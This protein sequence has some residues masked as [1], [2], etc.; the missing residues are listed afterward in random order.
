MKPF[1]SPATS[2]A[3]LTVNAERDN[4]WIDIFSPLLLL[5][6]LMIECFAKATDF[7]PYYR[8]PTSGIQASGIIAI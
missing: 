6:R 2:S 7:V 3:F 4:G 8:A 5:H 1:L